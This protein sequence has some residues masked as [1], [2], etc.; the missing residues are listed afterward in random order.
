GDAALAVAVVVELVEAGVGRVEPGALAQRH[1]GEHLGRA[2]DDRRRGVDAG[3][4]GQ[5]ADALGAEVLA[6][7][8][9]LLARERLRRRGVEGTRALAERLEVERRRDERLPRSRRRREHDVVA[10]REREDRLLLLEIGCEA[11]LGDP[12][13]EAA[14]DL[15]GVARPAVRDAARERGTAHGAAGARRE[16]PRSAH[17]SAITRGTIA[18]GPARAGAEGGRGGGQLARALR[19]RAPVAL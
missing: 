12:V 19:G 5:H 17:R 14:E 7:G 15:R 16:R 10:L 1:V 13:E 8:E 3:V 9:E 18:C 4:A 2:A 6:G 11:A